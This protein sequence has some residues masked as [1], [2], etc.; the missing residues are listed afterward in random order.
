MKILKNMMQFAAV[1]ALS[2]ASWQVSA[3]TLQATQF[4]DQHEKPLELTGQTQW[5]ILTSEKAAGKIAKNTFEEMQLTDLAAKG[6]IYV[7]DVSAM[8]GF[9]TRMFA[10][11]KMQDYAFRVAVVNEEGLVDDWPKQEDKVS[12]IKLNNLEI[13]SVDYFDSVEEL[14]SWLQQQM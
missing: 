14:Q 5:I 7:A 2:M 8:P 4:E 13:E 11:P 9:I 3:Q 12:A 1:A 10:I 6:G